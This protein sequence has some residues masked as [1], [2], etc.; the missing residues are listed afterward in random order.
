VK[1]LVLPFAIQLLIAFSFALLCSLESIA[2]TQLPKGK[3]AGK[4]LDQANNE[5]MIGA[6]VRI[7]GS[8]IGIT[9]DFDGKFQ[10]SVDEGTITLE[11]KFVGYGTKILQGIKVKA[12]ETT[13]I[14]IYLKESTI[15]TVEVQVIADVS[16][17]NENS[18]LNDQR[19]SNSIGSGVSAELL[20]KTPDRNL[21]ESF[22][23]ISG[24]S[25]RD[26]KFAMVRGLSERYNQGQLNGVSIPST[27]PDRKAFALDLFPSN[28]MDRIV[29]SKTATPDQPGD[30]AGG[31]IKIQTLDIPYSNTFSVTLAGENHALTTGK[32]YGSIKSSKTDWLGFDNGTRQHPTNTFTPEEAALNPNDQLKA[33]QS[34]IFNHDVNPKF[35]NA[36]P[37]ISGQIS[38]GRRGKVLG[39]TAGLVASISYYRTSTRNEF[40]A[41]DKE[42]GIGGSPD[43]DS[44][45][46]DRY[47]TNVNLAGILNFSIK[48]GASSKISLRN[49]FTQ[50]GVDQV[51]IGNRTIISGTGAQIDQTKSTISFYEQNSLSSNQLI[52]EKFFGTNGAKLEAIAGVNI[53]Y[54]LTPDFS[55][56]FYQRIGLNTPGTID[57]SIYLA[58]ITDKGNNLFNPGFTGK[59]FSTMRENSN[60][61]TLNYTQPFKILKV[62]NEAKAGLYY[63]VRD[64]TFDGRNYLYS[65]SGNAN[66]NGKSIS[67]LSNDSIFRPENFGGSLLV[68]RE[69]T[70]KSDF[71][72]AN[73]ELKSAFLMN[74]TSIGKLGTKLIYGFRYESYFQSITTAISAG[75]SKQVQRTTESTVVDWFPSVNANIN[76]SPKWVIRLAASRTVNRPEL[77][78]LAGFQFFDPNL[79]AVVFGNDTLVR[80][81]IQNF[82]SKVEFYPA[83]GTVFSINGFYKKF[84]NPIELERGRL[85]AFPAFSYVNAVQAENF[86]VEFEI[87]TRFNGL[88]SLFGTRFFGDLLLFSNLA[89]I[90]SEVEVLKGVKS[91]RPIQGQ[92][93]YVFNLGLQYSSEKKQFDFTATYNVVGPRVA[94]T[95][96]VYEALIWERPRDIFDISV[97]KTYKKWNFKLIFGDIFQQDLIQFLVLDRGGRKA[98][99][100]GLGKILSNVPNYQKGQDVPYFRY[101]YGRTIRVSVGLKF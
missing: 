45:H 31:L 40:F 51:Q 49:F 7:H 43:V 61:G 29:V 30:F 70:Q 69:T 94:F 100:T 75:S 64:R 37:N 41:V 97:G 57:S 58:T 90:R 101:T 79:N 62:K 77:R 85:I 5:A 95:S 36:G 55:R 34:K 3:I 16:K 54:R 6:A 48:P 78:E 15:E 87:R 60:S 22:R 1:R 12:N 11:A 18:L 47:K 33:N 32:S 23:R 8:N 82:D 53:L 59:F 24:T 19:A 88:D 26:G 91:K 73:T 21:S 66:V 89:I 20:A 52:F 65:G 71:Y 17:N 2:Q 25:I 38:L 27:E 86:G 93:P 39:K 72:K 10:F 50:T 68:L 92:S 83:P 13:L 84:D 98:D 4:I 35:R 42:L 9:A 76:I 14:T 56:L 81:S 96:L 46:Q 99:N 74:E 67:E 80:A 44:T 63:Q 28:L